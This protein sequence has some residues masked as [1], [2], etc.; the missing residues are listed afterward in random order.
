MLLSGMMGKCANCVVR[1]RRTKTKRSRISRRKELATHLELEQQ[2][3]PNVHAVNLLQ[4]F[5]NRCLRCLR[6]C[7]EW[8]QWRQCRLPF[9]KVIASP[10]KQST[11]II[12]KNIP[13][14]GKVVDKVALTIGGNKDE[15]PLIEEVDTAHSDG[16]RDVEEK[17]AEAEWVARWNSEAVDQIHICEEVLL[18]AATPDSL[19]IILD[20]GA[21]STVVGRSWMHQ[22]FKNKQKPPITKSSKSFESVTRLSPVVWG[23]CSWNSK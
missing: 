13:A 5:D 10:T 15:R 18:A 4:P 8:H 16:N 11:G 22:F 14:K 20:S 7:Q 12:R 9:Q 6:C 21:T 1:T 3:G 19:R 17:M 23:R 2:R